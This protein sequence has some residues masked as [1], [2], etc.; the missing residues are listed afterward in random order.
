[1]PLDQA[2]SDDGYRDLDKEQAVLAALDLPLEEFGLRDPERALTPRAR[3]RG[4]DT[5]RF[6]TEVIPLLAGAPGTA[7]DIGGEPVDY[8]EAGDSLRIGVSTGEVAGETDWFDLGVTITVEGR[9]VPFT[10]VFLALDADESHLLMPDGAYFSLH[11]P[12]LQALRKRLSTSPGLPRPR[13]GS[14]IA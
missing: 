10:E 14:P 1:V 11:K 3:L 13:T 5:L 9:Q 6:T 8:R 12:E 4:I 7:V 2:D